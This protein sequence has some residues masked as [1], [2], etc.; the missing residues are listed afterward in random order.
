MDLSGKSGVILGVANERSIAWSIAQEMHA[1]GARLAFNYQNERLA[2]N[3]RELAD[4]MG[5][6]TCLPCD[7]S[8]DEQ[9]DR[10][11]GQVGVAFDGKLDFLVHSVAFANKEELMGRYMNTSR[12]GFQLAMDV[13]CYSLVAA[14]RRAAPLMKAAGGGAIVTMSFFGAEK[15]VI[16]YNVMGVAKAA[17]EA[18]VRYLAADMGQDNIR[19]NAISAGAVKTLAARGISNFSL[20]L[21]ISQDRSP[22]KR[23]VEP[24]E[25]GKTATFLCSDA[26]SGITGETLYV[27]TGYH[28]MGL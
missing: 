10:F 25:I 15:V 12:A 24:R 2:G 23:N 11:F 4:A 26:S 7:L 20:M 8:D 16:N 14:T 6:V 22:M 1:A 17:L 5:Q 18:S 9:I 13:S 21:Q 19:V 28:I 27:D 3:V